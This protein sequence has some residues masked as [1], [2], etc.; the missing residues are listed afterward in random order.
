MRALVGVMINGMLRSTPRIVS[1]ASLSTGYG[2]PPN[3]VRYLRTLG[4]HDGAGRSLGISES[5]IGV[6]TA[7]GH[8]AL[9]RTP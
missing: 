8:S 3:E 4:R 5:R 9:T 2:A 7:D 6:S 1:S